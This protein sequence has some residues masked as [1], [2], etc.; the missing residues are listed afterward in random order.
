MY[1]I[2]YFEFNYFLVLYYIICFIYLICFEGFYYVYNKK[3]V[4]YIKDICYLFL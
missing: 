3:K 2:C 4:L 1:V